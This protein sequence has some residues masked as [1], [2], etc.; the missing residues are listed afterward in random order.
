[1]ANELYP[2]F[3][4]V[5]QFDTLIVGG[6]NV[7]LEKLSFLLKSSPNAKVTL[8]GKT[9]LP[10]I[11]S[12]A[13]KHREV[14]LFERAFFP[15]DMT[16]MQLVLVATEDHDTNLAIQQE[17]KERG[18]LVNVADTPELCDFYLGSI[19]SKGDLKIGIS[20]NGQSPTIAKRLKEVLNE[21]LPEEIDELLKQMKV[22]RD[23]LKGN[24]GYKVRKLNQ[25]TSDL[26]SKN[27]VNKKM[28]MKEITVKELKALKD[29]G[30]DFQLI[31]VREPYEAEIAEIGGE[32]IPL[33]TVPQNV[34]KFAKDKQV[35]VHC[36]SGKR[37]GDAIS[38]LE[39]H[40]GFE[41]LYNLK[42]GIL[43]WADE[44]DNNTEKY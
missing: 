20:T 1:M 28:N 25:L 23:E 10:E 11:K 2:V 33:G 13:A 44:I 9:I 12:L 34:D 8:V 41:N 21:A 42:G 43:A 3:L 30:A 36:R 24:F 15:E 5:N 40:H 39:N 37:S 17:A 38:W 18:I 19:V 4:K 7:G 31:D 26:V 27:T 35:V 16:G 22:I 6:G 29:S 14:T 32:L